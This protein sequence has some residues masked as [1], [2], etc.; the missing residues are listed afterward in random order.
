MSRM[1]RK[2]I[3]IE[4]RQEQTLKRRARELAISEAE[5]VR[6]AIDQIGRTP[7]VLSSDLRLSAW[8]EAKALIEERMK[9]E[10]PQTGRS[11]T[12]DELYDERLERYSD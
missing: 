6:R 4:P 3:Y 5:V 10:V 1:V 8:Q 12:R 11:W 2:Q 9:I 7:T